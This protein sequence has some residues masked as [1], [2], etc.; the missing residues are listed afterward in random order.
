MKLY[1]KIPQTVKF[2]ANN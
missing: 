2:I 1:G